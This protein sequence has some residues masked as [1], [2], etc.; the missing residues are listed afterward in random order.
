MEGVLEKPKR[1]LNQ[2]LQ[3]QGKT[4]I[5]HRVPVGEKCSRRISPACV[6][7]REHTS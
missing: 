4:N 6:S 1:I 5:H 3:E 7:G 2:T